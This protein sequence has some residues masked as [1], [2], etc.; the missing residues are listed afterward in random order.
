VVGEVGGEELERVRAAAAAGRRSNRCHCRCRPRRDCAQAGGEAH[1]RTRTRAR[2]RKKKRERRDA[3][4]TASAITRANGGSEPSAELLGPGRQLAAAQGRAAYSA[5]S[6]EPRDPLLVR[7]R[8]P[9]PP[10]GAAAA[11]RPRARSSR[12]MSWWDDAGWHFRPKRPVFPPM[13]ALGVRRESVESKPT[14][15]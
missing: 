1:A 6:K 15:A 3:A 7:S 8:S 10:S 12:L 5:S 2:E 9:R 4:S 11:D 14:H 13:I